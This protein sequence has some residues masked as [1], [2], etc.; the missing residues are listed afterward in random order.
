[1][2]AALVLAVILGALV[3]LVWATD[4]VRPHGVRTIY[5]AKCKPGTWEGSRCYGRL[6]AGPAYR[7]E[8]VEAS[9]EV[10]FW[11]SDEPALKGTYSSCRVAD[12]ANWF[13]D[14]AAETVKTIAHQMVDDHPVSDPKIPTVP[15]HE[16]EKWRWLLLSIGV[17]VG[18]A[19]L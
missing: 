5:T 3:T 1:M 19:A 15:F 12:R 17:P 18:H 4:A 16:I 2:R 9:G 8:I 6:V 14:P 11:S 10:R 7:F 13:C